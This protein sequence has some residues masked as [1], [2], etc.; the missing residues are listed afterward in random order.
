M[1]ITIDGPVAAG[2]TTTAKRIAAKLSLSYLDTGAFYRTFAMF[3]KRFHPDINI[4]N[5]DDIKYTINGFKEVFGVDWINGQQKLYL[6]KDDVSGLIR[7]PE[8]SE[9]ASVTSVY[10]CVRQTLLECFR[11]I[12]KDNGNII[13]EGRDTGSN[14][15]KDE[16]DV[17]FYLDA[18]VSERAKRRWKEA[19]VKDDVSYTKI[20][21]DVITRDERDMNRK[22]NPLVCTNDMEMINNTDLSIDETVDKI[23]NIIKNHTS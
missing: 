23:C 22:E 9:I 17:K 12:I 5:E 19:K 10:P 13:L 16:A 15:A 11:K 21:E 8:I 3:L 4:H 6:L 18:D 7:T 1:I 2:K 20:L 14:V